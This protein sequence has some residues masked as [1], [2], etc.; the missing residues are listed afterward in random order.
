MILDV[1]SAAEA[2][3]QD[4]RRASAGVVPHTKAALLARIM[5]L[6]ESQLLSRRLHGTDCAARFGSKWVAAE[7]RRCRYFL[8]SGLQRRDSR[9]G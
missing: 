4:K 8:A 9:S 6:D 2:V 3:H 7:F 1:Q 5:V